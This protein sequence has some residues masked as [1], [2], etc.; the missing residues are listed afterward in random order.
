M[1]S[2]SNKIAVRG[3]EIS[4][5]QTNQEDY[6]CITDIAKFKNP[7]AP[8][9][10]PFF[11]TK[12]KNMV[13]QFFEDFRGEQLTCAVD[14]AVP[15]QFFVD[16]VTKEEE[17]VHAHAAMFDQ[18]PVA[19]DV[20][21]VTHQTQLEEYHRVN[22]LLPAMAVINPGRPVKVVKVQNLL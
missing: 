16:V 3:L 14:G 10:H 20:F 6:I 21:Q 4:F 12:G 15:R 1:K 19:D 9:Y 2:K 22:A 13:E 8:A 7:D 11:G 17:D 5:L 18:L